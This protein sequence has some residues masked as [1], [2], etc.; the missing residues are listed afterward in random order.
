MDENQP[1][2]TVYIENTKDSG[3]GGFTIPLPT[4][5]EAFAPWIEAVGAEM[6]NQGS[7]AIR[8]V[9]GS[10]YHFTDALRRAVKE[11]ATLN[12]LNYL[13]F[14][15]S[16]MSPANNNIFEAAL[17]TGRYKGGIT[18]L[19]NLTYNLDRFCL[20]PACSDHE[21]GETCL[22][23]DVYSHSEAFRRLE[24]SEDTEDRAL[25]AY[26][27]KLEKHIDMCAYGRDAIDAENGIVTENGILVGGADLKE[28]Y[29]GSGDI[30][31]EFRLF[32]TYPSLMET[33]DVELAMG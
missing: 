20:R 23:A 12:E 21:Y 15:V 1:S 5:K 6:D 10:S 29:L 2:I 25:A 4:T 32:P 26:I 27:G 31:Q 33:D 19:I 8:D 9:S 13:A 17:E 3:I 22:A 14:K 30:P 24:N 11:G 7:I 18:E 28:S 16:S